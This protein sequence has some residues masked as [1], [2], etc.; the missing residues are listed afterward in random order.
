MPRARSCDDLQKHRTINTVVI[1]DYSASGQH[2]TTPRASS[3]MPLPGHN[4]AVSVGATDLLG[5]VSL[6]VERDEIG[7]AAQLARSLPNKFA[8]FPNPTLHIAV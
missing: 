2:M 3:E 5:I 8:M 7:V 6:E 4:N 1:N